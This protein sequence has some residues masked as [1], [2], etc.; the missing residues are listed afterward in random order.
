MKKILILGTVALNGGDAAI[1]FSLIQLIKQNFATEIEFIVYDRQ[2]EVAVKYYPENTLRLM[3][4]QKLTQLPQNKHNKLL[5]RF[6]RKIH[7]IFRKIINP[8]RFYLATFLFSKKQERLAQIL[9]TETELDDIKH[10]SNANIIISTGGTYL[11]ENYINDFPNRIFDY[12]LSLL[13]K[14]PLVFFTQSLGPFHNKKYQ[15]KLN[16]I[17]NQS[18]LVLLR[19]EKS[20]QHLIDIGVNKNKIQISSDIVFS[21]GKLLNFVSV[22]KDNLDNLENN[23]IKIAIS[24]RDWKFFKTK[25]SKKGMINYKNCLVE[26]INHLLKRGNIIIDFISTCQGIPEY[27]TDDSIT[28]EE[29]KNLLPIEFQGKVNVNSNFNHP[30]KLLEILSS[31]DLV[32]GTRMHMCILSLVARTPVIPIAYEF[33]TKELFIRLGMEDWITDI[34]TIDANSFIPLVENFIASLPE[35]RQN[36]FPKVE[37]EEK[38]ALQS[39]KILL[40]KYNQSINQ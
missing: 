9:V 10:F 39:G 1:L 27:H 18:L 5:T 35:I 29:I 40:D 8:F 28:A 22:S 2:P 7:L 24:V 16:H 30:Y 33:K 37:I 12:N 26:L 38:R 4:Y 25:T 3:I 23:Q 14:C 6:I 13:L 31:Y 20:E 21:L 17:F 34:E 19:D 11:V 36:L 32:I 15:K